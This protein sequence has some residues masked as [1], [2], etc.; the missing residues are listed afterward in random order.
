MNTYMYALDPLKNPNIHRLTLQTMY[1][2]I[3]D[4]QRAAF[5]TLILEV[6]SHTQNA[7]IQSLLP[8][9]QSPLQNPY[10]EKWKEA[11]LSRFKIILFF[12]QAFPGGGFLLHSS[13]GDALYNDHTNGEG[14]KHHKGLDF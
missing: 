13:L 9:S 10:Y 12:L 2:L 5:Y 11:T 6:S 14:S 4:L 3:G 7:I 1:H 8:Q